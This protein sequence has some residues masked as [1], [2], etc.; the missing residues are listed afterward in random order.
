VTKKKSM[1][2]SSALKNHI[3]GNF[4]CVCESMKDI[5]NY[6]Y[7]KL[8]DCSCDMSKK[9]YYF[10]TENRVVFACVNACG[11]QKKETLNNFHIMLGLERYW[12]VLEMNVTLGNI[13]GQIIENLQE[14]HLKIIK[15][16]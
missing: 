10:I 12:G 14:F 7:W 4:F 13:Y 3:N 1:Q 5:K 11:F 2:S 9:N 15:S 8:F 6:F 16:H